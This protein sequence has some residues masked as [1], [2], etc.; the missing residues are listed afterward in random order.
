MTHRIAAVSFLNTRPLIHG[1]E[2]RPDIVVARA[3]PSRLADLLA[4]GAA[5]VALLPV[6]ETFRGRSG[7]ILPGTGIACG[8]EVGSVKLFG[9][10]PLAGIGRVRAD[11][12]SRTSV[13]LADVLLREAAGVSAE[14]HEAEPIPGNLPE[15]GEAVL[16]IGDRC[17]EYE[18]GIA[19]TDVWDRDLGAWWNEMTGLPF[20][21]AVWAAR[22]GLADDRAAGLA[23]ILAAA[24]DKGL[25]AIEEIAA[26]AAAEGCLGHAGEATAEAIVYYFRHDLTYRLGP[27][28]ERGLVRFHE[29]CVRHG[30][31]PEGPAPAVSRG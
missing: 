28:E 15:A 20:V 30:L 26:A 21:F 12:G 31:A 13:A 25:A 17:F 4:A 24:R 7:S 2:A 18:R 3:L 11:R 23:D 27:A 5:D 9:R 22:P 14:F 10:G 16:V 1:L 19:G 8:G 29:L 6:V